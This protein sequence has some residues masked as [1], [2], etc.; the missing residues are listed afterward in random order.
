MWVIYSYNRYSKSAKELSNAL[1]IPIVKT[2]KPYHKVINWGSSE[3]MDGPQVV[4][5]R[6][7]NISKIVNKIRTF[8]FLNSVG[9]ATVPYT[10]SRQEAATWISRGGL[11]YCRNDI[12]SSGGSGITIAYT[13]DELPIDCKLF[14]KGIISPSEYRVH[15]FNNKVID[16][17]QKKKVNGSEANPLIRNYNNNWIF[18]RQ[19]IDIPKSIITWSKFAMKTLALDFGAIDILHKDGKSFLLEINSAPGMEGTTLQRYTE[20]FR[21]V[22][23]A[24]R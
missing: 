14:T 5:N 16:V 4:L 20:E 15:V 3:R 11:V 10:L 17:T 6:P 19:D 12:A 24:D 18:A 23:Y 13:I 1:S 2:I 9:V 21:K 8:S 7:E 22:V